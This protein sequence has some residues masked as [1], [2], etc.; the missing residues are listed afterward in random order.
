MKLRPPSEHVAI[1]NRPA[2]GMTFSELR[3]NRGNGHLFL[4]LDSASG[5]FKG[6]PHTHQEQLNWGYACLVLKRKNPLVHFKLSSSSP[7]SKYLFL[8]HFIYFKYKLLLQERSTVHG[9]PVTGMISW[10]SLYS[11]HPGAGMGLLPYC[12]WG[13]KMVSDSMGFTQWT[14]PDSTQSRPSPK[15]PFPLMWQCPLHKHTHTHTK[16]KGAGDYFWE[17]NISMC[18]DLL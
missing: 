6:K 10:S 16:R 9:S 8:P 3:D 7:L 12:R 18:L 2:W 5:H 14:R 13:S 15:A 17:L 4:S 1:S 11:H